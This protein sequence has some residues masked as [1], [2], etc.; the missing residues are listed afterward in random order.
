MC[1]AVGRVRLGV[2]CT[3]FYPLQPSILKLLVP[4][5]QSPPWCPLRVLA[6][7]HNWQLSPA[8]P[9]SWYSVTHCLVAG[10]I[11]EAAFSGTVHDLIKDLLKR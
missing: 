8:Q 3:F 6:I 4:L 2:E 7:P 9:I 11:S 1:V 10:D 5:L